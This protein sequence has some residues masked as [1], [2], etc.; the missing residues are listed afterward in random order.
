MKKSLIITIVVA[1]VL[2][3]GFIFLSQYQTGIKNKSDE[4]RI[5]SLE[6]SLKAFVASTMAEMYKYYS[7]SKN[8]TPFLD[9][10]NNVNILDSKISA[11][12][13][14]YG[15][16]FAYKVYDEKDEDAAVKVGDATSGIYKCADTKGLEVY[17]IDNVN[18]SSSTDCAGKPLKK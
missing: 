5:K 12:K 9:N 3:G 13:E 17:N 15:D 1:V 16:D 18:F 8:I 14:K 2:L 10:Q 11:L 4:T 6:A 7:D